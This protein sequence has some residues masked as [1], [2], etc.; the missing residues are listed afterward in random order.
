[1][2]HLAAAGEL[3]GT[4]PNR[5]E[6]LRVLEVRRCTRAAST[7]MV[8]QNYGA[9]AGRERKLGWLFVGSPGGKLDDLCG[10]R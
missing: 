2:H 8:M 10:T 5:T 7:A 4:E 3:N 1:M 9:R 6:P